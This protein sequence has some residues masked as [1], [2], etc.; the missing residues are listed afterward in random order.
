MDFKGGKAS[1]V[2][3][4]K[5]DS[6]ALGHA[7]VRRARADLVST[8]FEAGI[9]D[10]ECVIPNA[11]KA[12][13]VQAKLLEVGNNLGCKKSGMNGDSLGC[14][15]LLKATVG[16]RRRLSGTGTSEPDQTM[17]KARKLDPSLVNK[18]NG[19]EGSA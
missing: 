2:A 17:P 18:C 9:V 4:S 7:S 15:E 19:G 11:R 16:L 13:P 3:K 12:K 8:L 14:A 6:T 1:R 10:L 5:V